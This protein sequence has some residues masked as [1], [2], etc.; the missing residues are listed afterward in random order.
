LLDANRRKQEKTGENRSKQEREFE[1]EEFKSYKVDIDNV[2]NVFRRKQSPEP[3]T[4]RISMRSARCLLG[5]YLRLLVLE[6]PNIKYEYR[7]GLR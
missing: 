5:R 1:G 2:T 7:A 6:S 3:V 4:S